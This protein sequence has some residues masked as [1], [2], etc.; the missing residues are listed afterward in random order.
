[1]LKELDNWFYPSYIQGGEVWQDHLTLVGIHGGLGPGVMV[2]QRKAFLVSTWLTDT[3]YLVRSSLIR[4]VNP[5]VSN[6]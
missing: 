4:T 2:D 1:M 3:D 5:F 6:H